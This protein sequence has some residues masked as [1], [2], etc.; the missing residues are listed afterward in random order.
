LRELAESRERRAESGEQRAES[1]ER[2]AESRE[3]TVRLYTPARGKRVRLSRRRA[4]PF[5]M[6]PCT[7]LRV[8]QQARRNA[9]D[10]LALADDHWQPRAKPL[11]DQLLRASLSVQLNIAEGY[12]VAMKGRKLNLWTTAYGSAVE[13]VNCLE[14]LATAGV[15]PQQRGMAMAREASACAA[16]ILALIRAQRARD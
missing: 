13:T 3:Q 2:R 1:R 11:F 9:L 5:G 8:W 15:I 7:R 12:G 6:L 4:S 10:C 16:G 14:L